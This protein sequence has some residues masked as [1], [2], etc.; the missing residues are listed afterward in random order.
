MKK[1]PPRILPWA[2]AFIEG[3]FKDSKEG[4]KMDILGF[5]AL[6]ITLRSKWNFSATSWGRTVKHNKDVGGVAGSNHVLWLGLDA[7]LEPMGKNIDFE[8]DAAKIGLQAIFEKD[9]YHLQPR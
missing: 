8:A 2:A 5:A 9:H 1:P 3:L 6:V 7:I 4:L